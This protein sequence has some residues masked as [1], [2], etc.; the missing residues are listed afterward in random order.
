[1]NFDL[2]TLVFD[3]TQADVD[4][5]NPKGTYNAADMNRVGEAVAYIRDMF[6]EYGYAVTVSPRSDWTDFDIPRRSD[7]A[8]YLRNVV[9]LTDI[10][11]FSE[12]PPV[13]PQTLDGLTWQTANKIENTLHQLGIVAEKIPA[14]WIQ[15]G[16]TESGVAYI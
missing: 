16:Q 3:R 9:L 8:A 4:A 15:S 10:V 12:K 5:R 14:L 11:R 1:M 2:S 13:L 7:M 6:L